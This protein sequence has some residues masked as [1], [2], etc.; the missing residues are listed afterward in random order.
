[1]KFECKPYFIYKE[2]IAMKQELFNA[3]NNLEEWYPYSNQDDRQVYT[4]CERETNMMSVLFK[5]R[6]D[7]NLIYPLALFSQVEDYQNWVPG[8]VSSERLS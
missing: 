8:V 3:F 5:T 4:K 1:M 2:D 7:T 6:I